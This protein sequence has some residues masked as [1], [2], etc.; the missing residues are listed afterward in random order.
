MAAW[1]QKPWA[2]GRVLAFG[3]ETEAKRATID[4]GVEFHL[5]APP[6]YTALEVTA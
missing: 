2:R 5:S 6:V 1:F 3:S 4:G